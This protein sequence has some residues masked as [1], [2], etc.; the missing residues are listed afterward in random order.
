MNLS[1]QI[2]SYRAKT[3]MANQRLNNRY[4]YIKYTQN[5]LFNVCEYQL[6]SKSIPIKIPQGLFADA[7][8]VDADEKTQW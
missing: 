1:A 5:I 2:S 7:C 4:I 8:L 3:I 6:T